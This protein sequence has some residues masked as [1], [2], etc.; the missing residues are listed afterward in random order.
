M[1]CIIT[2]L[3]KPELFLKAIQAYFLILIFRI[4]TLTIF[5]LEPPEGIILLKDPF[6]EHFFYGQV[7][8]TKDLFFSGHVATVCLLYLVNPVKKLNWFYLS[9]FI[10][11]AV[12]IM[13]QRVHYSFDVLAAPV[14]A[15]I[16]WR[17][18]QRIR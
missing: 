15:W 3:S 18:A 2:L 17:L 14:F 13:V 12:F 9:V 4:I 11:V 16:S 5:P 1:L 8:I 10:L 7:R 6:I